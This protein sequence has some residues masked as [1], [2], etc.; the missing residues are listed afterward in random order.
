MEASQ[1][2]AT[3]GTTHPTTQYHIPEPPTQQ[4]SIISL[5]HLPNTVSYPRTTH[6]TTQ[7]HIP[8]PPTQP[9]SIFQ[10][11]LPNNTVLY[12]RATQQE[13]SC[14]L[15]CKCVILLPWSSVVHVHL[16]HLGHSYEKTAFLAI[17][18]STTEPV[19]IC[20]PVTFTHIAHMFVA[21]SHCFGLQDIDQ[22][23]QDSSM[24]FTFMNTK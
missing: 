14:S 11:H 16:G 24:S 22:F 7:Y 3:V 12:P 8:E 21:D 9:H 17:S 5:N 4:H 18:K 23:N 6:P 20:H 2:F 1:P 10:N 13:A 19:N 15:K